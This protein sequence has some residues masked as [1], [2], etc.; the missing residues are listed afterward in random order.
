MDIVERGGNRFVVIGGAML[1][2]EDHQQVTLMA[3]KENIKFSEALAEYVRYLREYL[4]VGE[5][6]A[7]PEADRG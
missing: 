4:K 3:K 6:I 5:G 2:E 7:E 1:H